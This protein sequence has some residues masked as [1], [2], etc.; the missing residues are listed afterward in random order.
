MS[1]LLK[2]VSVDTLSFLL[3]KCPQS[4]RVTGSWS[5]GSSRS[6]KATTSLSVSKL[7]LK[8]L[9]FR[10]QC[11][12]AGARHCLPACPQ[13]VLPEAAV[14]ALRLSPG[15]QEASQEIQWYLVPTSQFFHRASASLSKEIWTCQPGVAEPHGSGLPVGVVLSHC[16][17]LFLSFVLFSLK[18]GSLKVAEVGPGFAL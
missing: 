14:Q 6:S 17:H 18:T 11:A 7:Q 2:Q 3:D 10:P 4:C 15:L 16:P 13:R 9:F 12:R 5:R 8:P 1:T